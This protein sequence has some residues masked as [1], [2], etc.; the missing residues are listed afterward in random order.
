MTRLCK[1][2]YAAYQFH[3]NTKRLYCIHIQLTKCKAMAFFKEL[4]AQTRTEEEMR[5][6]SVLLNK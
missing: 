1:T 5:A 3:V 6:N 4:S 2:F